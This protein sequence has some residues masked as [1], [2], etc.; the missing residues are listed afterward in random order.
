MRI[1]LYMVV[2][3]GLGQRCWLGTGLHFECNQAASMR[4]QIGLFRACPRLLIN[5]PSMGLAVRLNR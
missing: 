3:F 1:L 5:A 2:S 4:V